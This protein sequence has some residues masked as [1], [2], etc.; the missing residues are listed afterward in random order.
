MVPLNP[1][2]RP[3]LGAIAAWALSGLP[4]IA[5]AQ[6]PLAAP[7][8]DPLNAQASVPALVHS[9]AFAA[10][11]RL[12]EVPVGSWRDANDLVWRIGGWR[13]YA[14]EA[15]RQD[16]PPA[17]APAGPASGPPAKA[18]EPARGAPPGHGGHDGHKTN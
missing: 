2:A 6:S 8:A 9:S 13:V 4:M 16:A 3:R 12:S 15:S 11:R 7:P 14:R 5:L 1:P 17:T 18:A 10:Y